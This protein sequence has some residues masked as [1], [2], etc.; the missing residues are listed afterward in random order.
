MGTRLRQMVFVL[1]WMVPA[2][3]A[4]QQVPNGFCVGDARVAQIL[5]AGLVAW[6]EAFRW[7]GDGGRV[8]TG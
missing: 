6:T 5:T 1:T 3:G 7:D 4:S 8:C 2:S